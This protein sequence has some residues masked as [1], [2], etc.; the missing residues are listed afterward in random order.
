MSI[1]NK[2][3]IFEYA[4]SEL[5]HDAFIAWLVSYSY[6]NTS[7]DD[8][9]MSELSKRFVDELLTKDSYGNKIID[10]SNLKLKSVERQWKRIDVL[11]NYG[12]SKF[13]LIEDKLL[14]S[15]HNEQI[16]K[17]KDLVLANENFQTDETSIC[18][19]YYKIYEECWDQSDEKK[20]I[21]IVNRKRL[22]EFFGNDEN[23]VIVQGNIILQSYYNFLLS[24]EDKYKFNKPIS[25]WSDLTY[26]GY[27]Q[28]LVANKLENIDWIIWKWT[29]RPSGGQYIC[30]WS[31]TELQ[32]LVNKLLIIKVA[33]NYLENI[34]FNLDHG[35]NYK[36]YDTV[37][38]LNIRVS[39]FKSVSELKE[40]GANEKVKELR[41]ILQEEVDKYKGEKNV[42]LVF[43]R[44]DFRLG[45]TTSLGFF[46]YTEIENFKDCY[47]HAM[48]IAERF[49]KRINKEYD[50]FSLQ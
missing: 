30:S 1:C 15:E 2:N 20:Y 49:I 39:F 44:K 19:V 40:M 27:Y 25:Q 5:S 8:V 50:K 36:G 7:Q 9:K 22:I 16:K 21:N 11:A 3:N 12:D 4:T 47:K 41:V 33:N 48:I 6:E 38:M 14:T 45:K 42:D 37:L 23:K 10:V 35:K 46:P 18:C 34:Y 29:H 32:T 28:Y 24:I 26:A 31:T 13:I 17:Y 43:L